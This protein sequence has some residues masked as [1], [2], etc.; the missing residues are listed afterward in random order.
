MVFGRL[1]SEGRW[2]SEE[3]NLAFEQL[4]V[5]RGLVGVEEVEKRRTDTLPSRSW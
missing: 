4:G 3:V 2:G 1:G 5:A